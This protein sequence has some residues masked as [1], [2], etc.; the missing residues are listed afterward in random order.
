MWSPSILVISFVIIG[1]RNE[2]SEDLIIE[3][4][5]G[6]KN[7]GRFHRIIVCHLSEL[8]YPHQIEG[9]TELALEQAN[10]IVVLRRELPSRASKLDNVAYVEARENSPGTIANLLLDVCEANIGIGYNTNQQKQTSDLSIRGR[11]NLKINLGKVTSQLAEQLGGFGG[12]HPR[13]S[14]ARIPTSTLPKFIQALVHQ[15]K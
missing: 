14:G 13:A 3:R 10:R 6:S 15:T 9:V 2:Y 1:Y 8:E 4:E 7:E 12:G 11:S 5:T